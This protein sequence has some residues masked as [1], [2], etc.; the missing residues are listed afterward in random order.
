MGGGGP[1]T[2]YAQCSY[3]KKRGDVD[4]A[5]HREDDKDAGRTSRDNMEWSCRVTTPFGSSNELGT[6]DQITTPCSF[7]QRV[8]NLVVEMDKQAVTLSCDI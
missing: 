7:P 1:L 2:Q 3:K 6:M 4:A 5:T 8:Y